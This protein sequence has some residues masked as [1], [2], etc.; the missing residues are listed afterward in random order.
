MEK[1]DIVIVGAGPGGLQAAKVLAE[2]DK[3]VLVLEKNKKIERKICTGLW[4]LNKKT[5]EIN[6][7]NSVYERKFKKVLIT[8]PKR[9]ENIRLEK[10]FVSTINRKELSK[11]QHKQAKKAGAEILFDSNVLKINS[12]NV[13]VDNKKIEFKQLIGADVRHQ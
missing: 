12:N 13:I 7:P 4:T 1:Y 5:A 3:K 11:W 6:L 2:N 10:P 8:T 9:K